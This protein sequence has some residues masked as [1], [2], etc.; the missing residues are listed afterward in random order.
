MAT[1]GKPLSDEDRQ[2]IERLLRS[3]NSRRSIAEYCGVAKRTVDKVAKGIGAIGR[4]PPAGTDVH[5]IKKRRRINTTSTLGAN[6][7]D[8]MAEEELPNEVENDF[9]K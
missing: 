9:E 8:W 2:R 7:E 1:P 4:R 3:G 5:S 6:D